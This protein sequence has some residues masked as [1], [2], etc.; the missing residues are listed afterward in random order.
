LTLEQWQGMT[1]DKINGYR[2]AS[3]N[4]QQRQIATDA[5]VLRQGNPF[6]GKT[7]G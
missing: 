7:F 2:R 3:A 4:A 5:K 6:V 1:E